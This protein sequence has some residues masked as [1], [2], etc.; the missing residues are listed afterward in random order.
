[1]RKRKYIFENA[2]SSLNLL[3]KTGAFLFLI[4][5]FGACNSQDKTIVIKQVFLMNE[6]DNLHTVIADAI[7]QSMIRKGG[8]VVIIPSQAKKDITKANNI[9]QNFY[10]QEIMAVHIL[11]INP[12][13]TLKKTEIL[14]IENA[15]IIC[16]VGEDGM[17]L[18][19]KSLLKTPLKNALNN[20]ACFVVSNKKSEQKL[21]LMMEMP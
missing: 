4:T 13:A 10:S 8:F 21:L 6:A 5:F 12:K 7:D 1:M 17:Y 18:K 2:I 15:K 9:K 3:T 19:E 20:N 11:N 16:L 14:T